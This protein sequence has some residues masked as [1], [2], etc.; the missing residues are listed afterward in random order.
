ML[1]GA[2]SGDGPVDAC[3][4]AIDKLTGFKGKLNDYVIQSVTSGKDA[5]GEVTVKLAAN[6]NVEHGR[7]ASTDIIEASS[8]A[9]LNA[10]NRLL[11]AKR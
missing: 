4:N 1:Q 9:Y 11:Y 5:L 8:R 6:G 10:I 3:Y 2:A 7:A